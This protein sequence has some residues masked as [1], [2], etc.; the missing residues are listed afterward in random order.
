MR[1]DVGNDPALALTGVEGIDVIAVGLAVLLCIQ[2]SAEQNAVNLLL[3]RILARNIAVEHGIGYVGIHTHYLI[4]MVQR[5]GIATA[6]IADDQRFL[7]CVGDILGGM[8]EGIHDL[9]AAAI[10]DRHKAL[11]RGVLIQLE[12]VGRINHRPVAHLL[13]LIGV[14]G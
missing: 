3:V 13:N 9:T 7:S 11:G 6:C 4:V 5:D 1:S 14:V 10:A 2:A 12:R 8:H